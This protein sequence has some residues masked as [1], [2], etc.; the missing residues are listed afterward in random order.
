MSVLTTFHVPFIGHHPARKLGA[1]RPVLARV[2]HRLADSPLDSTA[3]RV[4]PGP[5]AARVPTPAERGPARPH[6][7]WH[8]VNGPDG[9]SRLEATWH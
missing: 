6:A 9:R 7:H 4:A 3:I 5:A 1:V 8:T 2:L